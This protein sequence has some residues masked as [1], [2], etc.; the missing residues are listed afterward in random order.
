MS[1]PQSPAQTNGK[2]LQSASA[3]GS[4]LTRLRA[5]VY[6]AP[7]APSTFYESVLEY[8]K[9]TLNLKYTSLIYESTEDNTVAQIE[10]HEVDLGK[11]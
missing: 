6:H 8:L 10:N 7:D 4:L 3:T 11:C 1:P 9:T 2:A 5:G